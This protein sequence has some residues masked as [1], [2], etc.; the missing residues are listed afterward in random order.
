MERN[1]FAR[2]VGGCSILSMYLDFQYPHVPLL[3]QWMS[4]IELMTRHPLGV[5]DVLRPNVGDVHE[6]DFE[7]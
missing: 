6:A 1:H 7:F 2:C 3:L 5:P 4:A